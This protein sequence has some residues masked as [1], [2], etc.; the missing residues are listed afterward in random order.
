MGDVP[1]K[2]PEPSP[3]RRF[4]LEIVVA[5]IAFFGGLIGALSGT[6][7]TVRG[8]DVERDQ[9]RRTERLEAY[10]DVL[11]DTQ[12]FLA[13]VDAPCPVDAGP[14]WWPEYA[15]YREPAQELAVSMA[16]AELVGS[17]YVQG[18]LQAMGASTASILGAVWPERTVNLPL[19]GGDLT[20]L[21]L[22]PRDGTG[23]ADPLA[24]PPS[25]ATP[26]P[27]PIRAPCQ[28]LDRAVD[29]HKTALIDAL[30]QFTAAAKGELQ[31]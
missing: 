30:A 25:Q 22:S 31:G 11:A 27:Q 8:T 3:R 16:R 1:A 7:A 28:Q 26:P 13:V 20:V 5:L 29:D 17:D 19:I 10:G 2:A 12:A 15:S 4:R 21:D 24:T 6:L 9:A 23:T 18:A 14:D